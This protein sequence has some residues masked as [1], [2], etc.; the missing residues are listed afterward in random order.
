MSVADPSQCS[1]WFKDHAA[2]LTGQLSFD[3]PL[4][5]HTYYRIGG[6]ASVFAVPRSLQD[7][8]WLSEGIR[9]TGI[10]VF[11]L[12]SG[13]NLLVSDEG[14]AGLVVRAGRLDLGIDPIG[15]SGD[16][17]Q[18]LRIRTGGSVAVSTLLRR[19]A[20]DGWAGLELL[21]GI[22]GSIGGVVTMNAGTHL[23]EAKDRLRRVEAFD[24]LQSST[25][26]FD[27]TEF[28]YEY[29][30]NHFLPQGSIVMS[31]E[32]EVRLE[33]PALVKARIDETLLRR[34]TTQPL[35]Y[36]SCG[37]VFKNPHSHGLSAWQVVDR[38]GLRGHRI[39][40]AQFAQ[41]HSNFIVNLGDA[42]ASDVKALIALAKERA[43]KELGVLLE[44]EVMVL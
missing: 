26:V 9:A 34:K 6:P 25:R 8:Q 5:K 7:L 28:K 1:Q 19:A 2:R 38:L 23:G 29:R 27:S 18:P 30:K 33:E 44:E 3:E 11:V 31:A 14:F 20:H 32:W 17:G 13:S 10:P 42:S 43:L 39:G 36:P 12:G 40:G 15:A 37:S 35:D 24:L 41:K 22:P 16:L 4:S 21:T